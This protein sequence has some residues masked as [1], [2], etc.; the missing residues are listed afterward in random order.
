MMHHTD[1]MT[2]SVSV[3]VSASAVRP[4]MKCH[5]DPAQCSASTAKREELVLYCHDNQLALGIRY[6]L[7]QESPSLRVTIANNAETALSAATDG[8]RMIVVLSGALTEIAS[9]FQA[10]QHLRS[11]NRQFKLFVSYSDVAYGLRVLLPSAYWLNLG[12]PA[13]R[14]VQKIQAW[15][16]DPNPMPLPGTVP[17]LSRR[18]CDILLHLARGESVHDIATAMGITIKTVSSHRFDIQTK[19]NISKHTSWLLL[20]AVLSTSADQYYWYHPVPCAIA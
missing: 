16:N 18:Q 4:E 11:V 14:F 15:L 20:C 8:V 5:A 6:L 17:Q 2:V 12:E 3:S 1:S 19:L 13:H 9:H 10:L 7:Q